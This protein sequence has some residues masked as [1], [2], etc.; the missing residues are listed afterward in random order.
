MVEKA[1]C[2]MPGRELRIRIGEVKVGKPYPET[3][4]SW[5][6]RTVDCER[7]LIAGR[8]PPDGVIGIVQEAR[9]HSADPLKTPEPEVEY[10]C[11]KV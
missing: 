7:V 3:D 5:T 9:L 4:L 8:V 1:E 11:E 2:A 10:S 6:L